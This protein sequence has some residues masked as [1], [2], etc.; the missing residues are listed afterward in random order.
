MCLACTWHSSYWENVAIYGISLFDADDGDMETPRYDH[1]CYY[2]W[3]TNI[4]HYVINYENADFKYR[5]DDALPWWNRRQKRTGL[6]ILQM[7]YMEK[8]HNTAFLHPPTLRWNSANGGNKTIVPTWT[9]WFLGET[10][11]K[12]PVPTIYQSSNDYYMTP[13]TAHCNFGGQKARVR[14]LFAFQNRGVI[15]NQ[16]AVNTPPALSESSINTRAQRE[17][18]YRP[19][20]FD[21]VKFTL[22]TCILAVAAS[23]NDGNHCTPYW[24]I[25]ECRVLHKHSLSTIIAEH[26][27]LG[28]EFFRRKKCYGYDS[29]REIFLSYSQLLEGN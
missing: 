3:N 1:P 4:S 27:V 13:G 29:E 9:P 24:F 10:V 11:H 18:Q 6:D 15:H 28:S 16:T 17:Y 14:V 21:R 25:S 8:R 20:G 23:E 22:F 12:L 26:R 19:T 7:C 5:C 2:W